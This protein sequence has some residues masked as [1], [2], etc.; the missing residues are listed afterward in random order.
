MIDW[1]FEYDTRQGAWKGHITHMVQVPSI[2]KLFRCF[3]C[4]YLPFV[5]YGSSASWA[6]AHPYKLNFFQCKLFAKLHRISNAEL[7]CSRLICLPYVQVKLGV[8]VIMYGQKVP[9]VITWLVGTS[10]KITWQLILSREMP[11]QTWTHGISNFCLVFMLSWWRD[12][13]AK[14]R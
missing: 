8:K 1:S 2:C 4:F 3:S 11:N 10:S 5:C 6:T 12:R 13:R 7:Q 14:C 9:R